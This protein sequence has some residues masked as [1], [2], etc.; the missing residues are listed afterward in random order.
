MEKFPSLQSITAITIAERIQRLSF[1]DEKR[2]IF[3]FVSKMFA[4]RYY[5]LASA[6]SISCLTACAMC[7]HDTTQ[8]NQHPKTR[9]PSNITTVRTGRCTHER[10]SIT[11]N[12]IKNHG[13]IK[14]LFINVQCTQPVTFNLPESKKD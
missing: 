8:P 3:A 11:I 7:C 2:V 14:L 4:R 9:Q 6:F 12:L 1:P 10:E 13:A 5:W